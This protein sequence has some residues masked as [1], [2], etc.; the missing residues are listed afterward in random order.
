MEVT[1]FQTLYNAGQKKLGVTAPPTPPYIL[2]FV[3]RAF[4]AKSGGGVPYGAFPA[5]PLRSPTHS[6]IIQ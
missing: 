1:Q 6:P 5:F 2:Q 4:P 3:Y